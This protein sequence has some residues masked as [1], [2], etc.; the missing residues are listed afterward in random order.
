MDGE[1]GA[2]TGT[3]N[4]S[5]TFGWHAGQN[6]VAVDHGDFSVTWGL[7]MRFAGLDQSFEKPDSDPPFWRAAVKYQCTADALTIQGL[8][9]LGA[10]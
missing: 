1:S 5:Q 7:E 8:H 10:R 2:T 6:G 4:G 9:G 3:R